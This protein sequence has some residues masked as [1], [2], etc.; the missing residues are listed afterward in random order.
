MKITLSRNITNKVHWLL[1][2][3]L[4]P[5][6]RENK[7]M[8]R[9]LAWGIYGKYGKY[10]IEFKEN[11]KYLF[12]SEEEFKNYYVMVEP[13]I[14]RPT[15]I[16][17]ECLQLID[18]QVS[19]LE[20]GSKILDISCGRGFL[21]KYIATRYPDMYV[22]GC[23]I[24]IL[25]D[26]YKINM[27]NLK[28]VEGS[29]ENIPF[30]DGYFDCVISTHTLEHIIYAHRAVNELRR[31]CNDELIIVVPCQR[32]YK[33]TMDF[34]VQ[35]FPYTHSLIQFMENPKAICKKVKGDLFYIEK[36]EEILH[37]V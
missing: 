10:Y 12:L 24:N 13:I 9:I 36:R 19:R 33:Y 21:S 26:L 29:I 11:G 2:N 5:I 28:F 17:R 25:E 6:I 35:F 31:V 37:D 30:E 23:D 3:I 22:C 7:T 15:D 20:P 1:D 27:P 14:K 4:L 16:N 8:M 18:A 32:E 34:H